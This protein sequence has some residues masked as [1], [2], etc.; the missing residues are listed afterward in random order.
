MYPVPPSPPHEPTRSRSRVIL[1][2]C[3]LAIGLLLLTLILALAAAYASRL[4]IA[5]Q[6][7][8]RVI[9]QQGLGPAKLT[10]SRL[11]L[12]GLTINNI[13]L[14]QD[15]LKISRVEAIYS[16]RELLDGR[17]DTLEIMSTRGKL[18]WDEAGVSLGNFVIF[19]PEAE[20]SAPMAFPEISHV[21]ASGVVIDL[22]RGP[23]TFRAAFDVEA[24]NSNDT[25]D[26][27]LNSTAA[28]LGATITANWRG[29]VHSDDLLRSSGRGSVVF[30][31]SESTA[32]SILD[33]VKATGSL[34]IELENETLEILISQPVHIEAPS[35]P[36]SVRELL[37]KDVSAIAD[38][39]FVVDILGGDSGAF[40]IQ[41]HENT[42]EGRADIKGTATVG[43]MGLSLALRGSVTV[44]DSGILQKFAIDTATTEIFDLPLGHALIGGKLEL[45]NII[46]PTFES[47]SHA[48]L[49]FNAQNL[50]FGDAHIK[51]L[52]GNFTSNIQLENNR[53][54]FH[55][56]AGQM[57]I[58][59][60]AM[61]QAISVPDTTTF[62]LL[63]KTSS[64]P[65]TASLVFGD[66]DQSTFEFDLS[67]SVSAVLANITAS[68]DLHTIH[69][70]IPQVRASGSAPLREGYP[71][72]KLSVAEVGAEHDLGK[73][74]QVAINLLFN[75][76]VISGTADLRLVKAGDV[77]LQS[78][79]QQLDLRAIST[80]H[81]DAG[82]LS[83]TGGLQA[84]NRTRFADFSIQAAAD[85]SNGQATFSIANARLGS[86]GAI[87]TSMLSAFFPVTD[88]GGTAS[89]S[90]NIKWE[91]NGFT[92]SGELELENTRLTSSLVAVSGLSTTVTLDSLW[93]PRALGTQHVKV[94]N[95]E[96]GIPLTDLN[97]EIA[98]PGDRT[99][100]IKKIKVSVAGGDASVENVI[101]PLDDLTGTFVL[102]VNAID[103]SNLAAMADIDGLVFN[104]LL[105]GTI[106]IQF[107]PAEIRLNGGQ[108]S[109][110]APG[111]L[112]YRP[113]QSPPGFESAS[114]GNLLLQALNNFR[115]D[116]L[117]VT[118]NGNALDELD[119]SLAFQ[120]R[121]PDLYDG[122]PV[123]FNLALNGKF[124]EMIT[125]G[126]AGY[127]IPD[128]MQRGLRQQ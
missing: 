101:I 85:G 55:A 5:E 128:T 2:R 24:V 82:R 116:S 12:S 54:N 28:G 49:T 65:Q 70:N 29:L 91:E 77:E 13:S 68:E 94:N 64:A 10:I 79:A 83:A 104:G 119:V 126:L 32:A 53:L 97:A 14:A 59:D 112:Q 117:A 56:L 125:Q 58:R 40:F 46:G 103:V 38:G 89:L 93:P 108:L 120:G 106:P 57:R 98:W 39:K 80:F 76:S 25:W 92:H 109:S 118:A 21:H 18:T 90:A 107:S 102:N 30:D 114:G 74:D 75:G 36:A 110:I 115:Y 20:S 69:L 37:P 45:T 35:F 50:S 61:T 60:A 67:S 9:T 15:A 96:V 66:D 113:A 95:I 51:Q 26:L 42:S 72:I 41:R 44:D 11:D 1:R 6:I 47:L 78:P 8:S 23:D 27:N 62:R 87:D 52:A 31:V 99:A 100:Y 84:R 3:A 48:S 105:S 88:L 63:S 124:L 16:W 71:Q 86:G 123:S 81:I 122:Y 17:L 111:Y 33:G 43:S 19:D 121:N 7:A 34:D 22:K 127:R 4:W 73:I